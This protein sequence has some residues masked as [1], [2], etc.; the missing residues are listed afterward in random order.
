MSKN[1]YGTESKVLWQ[2]RKRFMGMPLSFTKYRLVENED[3]VKL[4][5][6]EGLLSTQYE[7][8]HAYRIVDIT[9]KQ[10]LRDKIFGVGT[11]ILHCDDSSNPYLYLTR[12][13]NPFEVRNQLTTLTERE[14]RVRGFRVT[15]FQRRV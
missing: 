12:I 5:K 3:W 8:V 2:D 9:L 1:K 6:S 4:F 11:I 14:K 15:E 13:K 10:T 7:E